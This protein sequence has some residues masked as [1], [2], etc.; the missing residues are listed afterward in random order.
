[1]SEV[2]RF[3]DALR[4]ISESGY[5]LYMLPETAIQRMLAVAR[6]ALYPGSQ[7]DAGSKP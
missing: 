3:R 6:E 2:E 1:M 7:S 4:K 5:E